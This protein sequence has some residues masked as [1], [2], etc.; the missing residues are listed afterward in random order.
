[1]RFRM[2]SPIDLLPARG[3]FGQIPAI[4]KALQLT[5]PFS[6]RPQRL[7]LGLV[8]HV[9][10]DNKSLQPVD[11]RVRLSRSVAPH[12]LVALVLGNVGG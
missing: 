10:I 2:S 7:D 11:L 4:R 6:I 3:F 9:L 1:M 5:P 8:L 12:Q